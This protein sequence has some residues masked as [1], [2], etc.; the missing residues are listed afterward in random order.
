M[1]GV[2]ETQLATEYAD[3]HQSEYDVVRR[4]PAD[5]PGRICQAPVEPDQRLGLVTSTEAN[6]AG[7]AVPRRCARGGR[8]RGGC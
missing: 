4:V 5:R 2:G 3:R 1:G 7:P 8:M 6:S